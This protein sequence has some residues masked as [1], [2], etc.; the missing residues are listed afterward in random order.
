MLEATN[1]TGTRSYWL[2]TARRIFARIPGVLARYEAT[3]D[4]ALRLEEDPDAGY[5]YY[6]L[7]RH[8]IRL[9][10][11]DAETILGALFWRF[12]AAAMGT[13]PVTAAIALYRWQ[14][15]Y[16]L[17]HEVGHHLRQRYGAWSGN[18]WIEE[19]V[20]NSIGF[21]LAR[22]FPHFQK[23]MATM[24]PQVITL[25]R[26]LSTAGGPYLSG[27]YRDIGDVLVTEG[28]AS[29]EEVMA[30]RRLG[31]QTGTSSVDILTAAGL[32]R[33]ALARA[34]SDQAA[35]ASHLNDN[36][37][38]NLLEYAAFQ[39]NWFA[40]LLSTPD[41]PDLGA[42]L[43]HHL[44]TPDWEKRRHHASLLF[45][46]RTVARDDHLAPAAAQV[47]VQEAGPK[48]APWLLAHFPDRS[49][50]AQAGII[51]AMALLPPEAAILNACRNIASTPGG[52]AELVTAAR[53]YLL[54][55]QPSAL[56]DGADESTVWSGLGCLAMPGRQGEGKAILEQALLTDGASVLE[57]L[58]KAVAVVPAALSPI[59]WADWLA[60][61]LDKDGPPGNSGPA[62][63]VLRLLAHS[64]VPR[65]AV[66][67]LAE[68]LVTWVVSPLPGVRRAALAALA[69]LP[70][71]RRR[72]LFLPVLATLTDTATRAAGLAD[73]A[74]RLSPAAPYLAEALDDARRW[75]I[76]AT[77]DIVA[78]MADSELAP[79]FAAALA[80][81][82]PDKAL[83]EKL[84]GTLLPSDIHMSV[85]R[86]LE[87]GKGSRVAAGKMG[88]A[89]FRDAVGAFPDALVTA[90]AASGPTRRSSP[91]AE[92]L[93][94]QTVACLRSVPLFAG[95]TLHE[96]EPLARIAGLRRYR[97]GE[98]PFT[99]GEPNHALWALIEGELE[100][101]PE[102]G[103]GQPAVL[104]PGQV[105]GEVSFLNGQALAVSARCLKDCRFLRLE[106]LPFE[107]FCLEDHDLLM[108]LGKH[109]A[110]RLREQ[111]GHRRARQPGGTLPGHRHHQP[112]QAI[113]TTAQPYTRPEKLV[114]L[115]GLDLFRACT[116][117]IK[118]DLL[119]AMVTMDFS[120]GEAVA[121]ARK[122]KPHLWLIVQ[123]YVVLT[124]NPWL[125]GLRLGP[126]ES[127]GEAGLLDGRPESWSALAGSHCR[128]LSL[129]HTDM[130]NFAQR[131]PQLLLETVRT[132][133]RWLPES[134]LFPQ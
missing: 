134:G 88:P 73:L 91:P 7:D 104:R 5:P 124:G 72:E 3:M 110:Q 86:L 38:G 44:L 43:E 19:H 75:R 64:A 36:Y 109:L 69:P 77:M 97:Q 47:L 55:H 35:S 70:A 106:A 66:E 37:L 125:E 1:T 96:L 133:S 113:P 71:T 102:S 129:P 103:G 63:T 61:F 42:V 131:N 123:G 21:A 115:A 116:G 118:V 53:L 85:L 78:A 60:P 46:Q 50:A 48:A 89:T 108:H 32:S 52:D 95:L 9:N 99:A 10:I 45:L 105:F 121:T 17:G 31:L 74:R 68:R 100:L 94:L 15:P 120:P 128:I 54:R 119:D 24:R 107:S 93:N 28:L 117:A 26:K 49:P 13:S 4:P 87:N 30:A 80:A 81:N 27:S 84:L 132:V 34:T 127:F 67:R 79:A 111:P 130:V 59:P 58:G 6:D 83:A 65:A 51:L 29:A 40:N 76:A 98:R 62:L 20:A 122:T 11:P 23:N 90:A 25:A 56:I 22:Q 16:L 101:V 92:E 57:P 2:Q 18:H 41:P 82:A 126:G 12:L 112:A 8:L 114:H 39:M 33:E 14:L